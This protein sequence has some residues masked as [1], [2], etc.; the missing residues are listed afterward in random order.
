M[1]ILSLT[2]SRNLRE[3]PLR[4]RSGI[5]RMRDAEH[6]SPHFPLFSQSAELGA[7]GEQPATATAKALAAIRKFVIFMDAVSRL[8]LLILVEAD[9][10][11]ERREHRKGN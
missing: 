11:R 4:D 7:S 2:I 9:D 10:E 1:F 5:S 6:Q 8:V 3:E